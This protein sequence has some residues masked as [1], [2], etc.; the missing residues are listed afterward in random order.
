MIGPHDFMRA[1][2]E[3][4]EENAAERER[5][6]IW[7]LVD[8]L[9]T[10]NTDERDYRRRVLDA[11]RVTTAKSLTQGKDGV[12]AVDTHVSDLAAEATALNGQT[13]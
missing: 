12:P 7:R 6:R 8:A 4:I 5:I 2:I 9:P 11:I 13:G 10:F 3:R 1:Q